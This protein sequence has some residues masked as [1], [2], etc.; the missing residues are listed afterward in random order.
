MIV[1]ELKDSSIQLRET[2]TSEDNVQG[3]QMLA[4]IRK[5]LVTEFKKEG[6]EIPYPHMHIVK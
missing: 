2:I 5:D 3:F 6:I 1:S 4:D